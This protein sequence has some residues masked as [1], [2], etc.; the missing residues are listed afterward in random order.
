MNKEQFMSQKAGDM[1][2]KELAEAIKIKVKKGETTADYEVKNP[3]VFENACYKITVDSQGR[4]L[5]ISI[6]S[7]EYTFHNHDSL[8]FLEKAVERAKELR[9][10]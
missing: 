7:E 10:R 9:E 3:N 6:G 1:S 4:W 5:D 8:P 2:I